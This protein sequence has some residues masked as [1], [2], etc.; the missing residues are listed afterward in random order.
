MMLSHKDITIH[1]YKHQNQDTPFQEQIV[2]NALFF[3]S[4]SLVSTYNSSTTYLRNQLWSPETVPLKTLTI[5]KDVMF[6]LQKWC[7]QQQL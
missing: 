7:Q 6:T 4:L 1:G 3:T 5:L 2:D